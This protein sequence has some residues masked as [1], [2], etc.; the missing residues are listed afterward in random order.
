MNWTSEATWHL[1]E[2]MEENMDG[3]RADPKNANIYKYIADQLVMFGPSANEVKIKIKS[4]TKLDG[5]REELPKV[6]PSDKT[7]SPVDDPLDKSKEMFLASHMLN[8]RRSEPLGLNL[9]SMS[10]AIEKPVVCTCPNNK[11]CI[12]DDFLEIEREKL[13]VLK[14]IRDDHLDVILHIEDFCKKALHHLE[15]KQ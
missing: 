12:I 5:N 7:S 1:V 4:L 11:R 14:S 3:L 10:R 6:G 2:L 15:N 8:F 9:D 13:E